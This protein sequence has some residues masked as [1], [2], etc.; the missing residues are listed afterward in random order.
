MSA[1]LPS[2]S[3]PSSPPRNYHKRPL[4]G[5]TACG[6]RVHAF[7]S[8]FRLPPPRAI[9]LLPRSRPPPF[10]FSPPSIDIP[11]PSSTTP[12]TL[13][14]HF[15]KV[16]QIFDHPAKSQPRPSRLCGLPLSCTRFIK[17]STIPRKANLGPRAYVVSPSA[18]V[19]F[20]KNNRLF[21]TSKKREIFFEHL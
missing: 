6:P 13:L 20:I 17:N 1:W 8:L 7:Y 10:N 4:M 3:P 11:P 15:H 9:P 19:R 12:Y 14:F 2:P 18:A 5:T 21:A 16:Y